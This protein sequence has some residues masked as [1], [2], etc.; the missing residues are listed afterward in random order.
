[1]KLAARLAEPRATARLR[2][3]RAGSG[4]RATDSSEEIDFLRADEKY[5][6]VGWRGDGARPA[7][8]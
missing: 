1:M 3:L 2:W 4:Q 6:L 8:H 7:K 5:T